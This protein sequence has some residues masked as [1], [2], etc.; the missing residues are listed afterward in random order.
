MNTADL[1]N[2]FLLVSAIHGFVFSFILFCSKNGKDRSM[3]FLNL[4]ILSISLNNI[5]SWA[6]AEHLFQHKFMLDYIQVP[7]HFLVA[8]FFYMFL[9]HYLDIAERSFN[10]LTYIAPIFILTIASQITFVFYFNDKATNT[11]LDFLYEKYTSFEEIFSLLVSIGIF[12]FSF[13]TLYKKEKLFPKILAFDDLQWIYSF[14]KIGFIMYLLWITALVI[15]VNL[16]FSGFLFSYYPL[17]IATTI[18]TYWLGYQG[19]VQLR[20]LKEREQIRN[21]LPFL[22]TNSNVV[23]DTIDV[24]DTISEEAE[25]QHDQFQKIDLFIKSKKKFLLPKYT[26]QN[27]S[28]DL[29]LS[30]STLSSI[31]NNNANKSFVDYINQM[32]VNQAK[33]LLTS[34]KY[35]QYTVTSI[36]LESG[37]NSK[38]SFY[39]VFKKHMNCTPERYKKLHI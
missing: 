11:E 38:S 22:A 27:L 6:L 10:I 18:L 14:F 12:S 1:F 3:L 4:L 33:E 5:Q 19:F 23:Y 20:I 25:K 37:F 21:S 35:E 31:I 30:P 39:A 2:L 32:R 17:R 9:I 24:S 13:Y 16:N 15:K 26:L 34:S 29:N 28:K 7:W 36:G 8:P